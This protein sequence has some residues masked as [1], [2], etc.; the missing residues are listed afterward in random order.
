MS[1]DVKTLLNEN[2]I[3]Y[4]AFYHILHDL[5]EPKNDLL[6]SDGPWCCQFVTINPNNGKI[7]VVIPFVMQTL[8]MQTYIFI[9]YGIWE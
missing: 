1:I 3:K 5:K 4:I 9:L 2:F 8:L 7:Q 6:A